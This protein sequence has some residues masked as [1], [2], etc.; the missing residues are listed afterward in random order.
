VS[1]AQKRRARRL[2]ALASTN[3][4]ES[5]LCSTTSKDALTDSLQP[6]SMPVSFSC[7]MCGP[8]AKVRACS[9]QH[10]RQAAMGAERLNEHEAALKYSSLRLSLLR[11]LFP[12]LH[13]HMRPFCD[14]ILYC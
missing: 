11:R 9:L 5:S 10:G 14:Y 4:A 8:S 7:T 1:D 3:I 6:A 12:L 2:D 13:Q